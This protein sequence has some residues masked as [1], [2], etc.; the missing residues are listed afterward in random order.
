MASLLIASLYVADVSVEFGGVLE[1]VCLC[2]FRN[3]AATLCVITAR[4]RE[5]PRSGIL[6]SHD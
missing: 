5:I 1:F 3:T 6:A 4:D 2:C